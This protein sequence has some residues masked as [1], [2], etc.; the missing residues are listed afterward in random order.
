MIKPINS[1]CREMAQDVWMLTRM[2]SL[3][4]GSS[5][6]PTLVPLQRDFIQVFFGMLGTPKKTWTLPPFALHH[7]INERYVTLWQEW[8]IQVA[9]IWWEMDE[10]GWVDDDGFWNE[11]A[12]LLGFCLLFKPFPRDIWVVLSAYIN[13]NQ[14]LM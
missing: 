13:Q 5:V 11:S 1:S 8:R 12:V 6:H 2:K 10:R 4:R 9:H 3:W 14:S 7:K